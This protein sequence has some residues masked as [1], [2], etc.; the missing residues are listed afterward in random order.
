MS[1]FNGRIYIKCRKSERRARNKV[2]KI[3]EKKRRE[4]ESLSSGRSDCKGNLGR[5]KVTQSMQ[6]VQWKG[7]SLLEISRNLRVLYF[8]PPELGK[9]IS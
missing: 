8:V 6:Y 5:G 3:S 1:S 7:R 9:M 4:T 2:K